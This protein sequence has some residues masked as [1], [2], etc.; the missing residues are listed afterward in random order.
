MA[1]NKLDETLER[2][3]KT[4]GAGTVMNLSDK[5]VIDQSQLISSGSLLI[6]KIL[7]GGI[8][9]G[10]VTEIYGKES[11][12]KS[13]LCLQLVRECQKTGGKVAYIDAEQALDPKYAKKLGVN[14]DD[15]I[16]AQP[17]NGEQ[18]LEIADAL[19]KSG[20]VSLI[21]VDSVSALTPQA[22]LDGEMGDA[23]I[24]QLARLMSKGLSKLIGTLNQSNCAIVF[25]NQIRAAIST[26]FSMGP[27]ETT[28]G[29]NALKF[30]A[31]QRIELRKTTAIKQG[32]DVVGNNVK[33]KVV[34]NKIDIP[35]RSVVLPFVFGKGFSADEEVYQLAIDYDIIQKSGAWFTTHDGQRFQGLP[36]VKDYYETNKAVYD[37][38]YQMVKDRLAGVEI[39]EQFDVDPNTGEI[40][41]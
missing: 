34:K 7:G 11:S 14:V 3:N 10:R 12:G 17:G 9:K 30:Y 22:V 26:G 20:E 23:H 32:E 24:G 29:G 2:L 31:S 41:E 16:F 1:K 35:M 28:T 36:R 25:I 33:V 27:T 38:L 37:E 4:F 39:E 6:D 5:P 18:A 21:I 8:A 19:A 13:T 40:I 15:L